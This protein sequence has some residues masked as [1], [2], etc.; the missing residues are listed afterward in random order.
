MRFG[1]NFIWVAKIE[2]G[3][4][5]F[6]VFHI[7]IPNKMYNHTKDFLC[8]KNPIILLEI[9]RNISLTMYEYWDIFF[10]PG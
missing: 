1:I 2:K 10:A 7:H 9:S 6:I 8:E 3:F 5:Y 4:H